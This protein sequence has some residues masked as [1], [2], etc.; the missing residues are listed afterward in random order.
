MG[1]GGCTTAVA[2]PATGMVQDP[3]PLAAQDGLALGE[4]AVTLRAE[5][6]DID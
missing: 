5:A 2:H 4:R 3:A 1:P 6:L